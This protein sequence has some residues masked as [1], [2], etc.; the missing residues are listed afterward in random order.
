M[1]RIMA[2][3]PFELFQLSV[4]MAEIA[5]GLALIG[6]LFTWWAAAASILMCLIFTLSGMFR[7]D[8]A[9]FFFTGILLLGGAGRAF[10]LDCWVVPVFK[11]WWNSLRFVR[12]HHWYLD[13]PSR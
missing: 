11:K 1:D 13:M 3:V 8:Q 5:I 9:W 4:V 10:G 2:H 7:W 6:G 12:R